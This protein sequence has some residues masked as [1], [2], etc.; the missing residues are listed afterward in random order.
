MKK[1]VAY[2][3]AVLLLVLFFVGMALLYRNV[4]RE[5]ALTTCNQL[6]V[7]FADTLQF[8]SEQ[9]I[10]EYLDTRYGTFIGQRLDSV[11]LARIEDLLAERSAVEKGEAWTTADGV[12]HVRITQRAPVLRFQDGKRSFY[13]DE[14]GTIFPPHKTYIASVPTVEG[15][16]PF[17]VPEGFRGEAPSEEAHKWITGMIAMYRYIS[18]SRTWQHPINTVRIREDGDLVLSLEGHPE[19]F[20]IGQPDNIRDKFLRIDRYLGTIAPSVGE[21]YYRTVNVK[22][23]HQIIC[24]QKDT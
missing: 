4:R 8:V 12:L 11:Q 10:R 21:G 19:Q 9:D 15:T 3:L 5:Q 2:I 23:N 24:R 13:V 17:A 14:N 22:Y 6:E 18:G 16:I 20:I 7:S 1:A